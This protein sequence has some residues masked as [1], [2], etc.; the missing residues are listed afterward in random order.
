MDQVATLGP[1]VWGL[2]RAAGL[3]PS[4]SMTE[5]LSLESEVPQAKGHT[6]RTQRQPQLTKVGGKKEEHNILFNKGAEGAEV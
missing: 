1:V 4:K 6:V 2:S 5:I 3:I